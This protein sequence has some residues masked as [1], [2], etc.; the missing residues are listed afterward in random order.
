LAGSASARSP[1]GVAGGSEEFGMGRNQV[2]MDAWGLD[3]AEIDRAT[4][5]Y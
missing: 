1:F 4:N 2:R 3:G 5:F